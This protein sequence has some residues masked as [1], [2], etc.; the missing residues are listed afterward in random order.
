MAFAPT[1]RPPH[2]RQPDVTCVADTVSEL[3]A[4]SSL[5]DIGVIQA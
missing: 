3:T 5:G 2:L 4:R 1:D